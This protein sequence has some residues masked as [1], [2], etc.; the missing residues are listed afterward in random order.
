MVNEISTEINSY[1]SFRLGEEL[2]SANVSKVLEILEMTRITKVPQAPAYM[3]GI[4]NL[5]GQVLPVIDTRTKFGLEQAPETQDTCIVVVEV[6]L[7]GQ[8]INLGFQVD[9]VE[10]VLEIAQKDVLPPPSIGS[11]YQSEFISGMARTDEEFLM[12]LNLDLILTS[13]EIKSINDKLN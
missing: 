2:F 4:I 6:L 13:D 7:N 3:R 11:N 5:R 9:A 8:K 1:L 10:E 12:I